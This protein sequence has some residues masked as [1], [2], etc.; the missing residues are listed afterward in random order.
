[1]QQS[2]NNS[3][4]TPHLTRRTTTIS[5][6]YQSQWHCTPPTFPEMFHPC[7]CEAIFIITDSKSIKEHNHMGNPCGSWCQGCSYSPH[8]WFHSFSYSQNI[9]QL[10][11]F[12]STPVFLDIQN[13]SYLTRFYCSYGGITISQ[14][15]VAAA[16]ADDDGVGYL[17]LGTSPVHSWLFMA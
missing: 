17:W 12:T 3:T 9:P 7:F 15:A 8:V 5:T 10:Y 14:D 1:M 2:R 11:Q 4:T 6:D 13:K 16:A